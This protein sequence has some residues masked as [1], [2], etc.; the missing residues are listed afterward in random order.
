M[1]GV[2]AATKVLCDVVAEV[3]DTDWLVTVDRAASRIGHNVS[4]ELER[5]RDFSRHASNER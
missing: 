5:K 3:V 2:A 4:R 1:F